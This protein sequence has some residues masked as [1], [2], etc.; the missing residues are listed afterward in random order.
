MDS[1]VLIWLAVLICMVL[2]FILSGMEAG[3]FA[4][5]RLRIR[6]QM[7][8]G[9]RSAAVLYGFLENS[10]NFLWTI[11]VGN[12]L[13]NFVVV[14]WIVVI[15]HELLRNHLV[16]FVIIFSFSVFL[17]YAF[18]DLLPKMLFRTYPNRLCLALARPF[19]LLH[20][21]LKPVVALVESCSGMLLR[22]RGGKTFTGHL[23]GNR[24]E[25]RLVMRE[26]AQGLTSEERVMIE[27]VLDLQ[28]LTVRQA[29]KPLS[30]A[31]TVATQNTAGEALALARQHEVTRLPVWEQRDGQKRIAGVVSLNALLFRADVDTKKPMA[32]LMTPALYVE[33]D[34][35]L[36]VAL[37]RM[38]RSGQRL[39]IV[40][41][42]DRR[43]TGILS[44]E[45]VLKVIFGE[46]SL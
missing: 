35:R 23:F 8:A 4:L 7:R 24:E 31:I 29:M 1:R 42:R 16:W 46:V 10:E 20:L 13:A 3:V 39:A 41:G 34:M 33:E 14:G 30:E 25:L 19:R 5:S 11:L 15:L 21:A 6:Q 27:R 2:S 36:E 9:R 40:L 17:F 44:L 38:Q 37:R 26:S 32:S 22:W 43:E 12:T 45:D 18:S 28:S